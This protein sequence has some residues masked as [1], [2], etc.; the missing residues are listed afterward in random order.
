MLVCGLVY[1]LL[2]L[3]RLRRGKWKCLKKF[4]EKEQKKFV[5]ILLAC[6]TLAMLL[7]AMD[8][9]GGTE[10]TE[11]LRGSYGE[12]SYTT[13]YEVS[14]E[15]ELEKE[16]FS[17]KVEEREYTE[18][19][20]QEIF[21]EMMDKL[22]V[23]VLGENQSFDRVEEDLCLVDQIE[24]YPVEIRWELSNYKVLDAEGRIL[25]ENT[26]KEGSLVELRARLLYGEWESVYVTNVMVYPKQK[27][28]KEKWL[29]LLKKRVSDREEESRQELA[30]SLPKDLEGKKV[31]WE[32]KADRRGYL[33][34]LFGVVGCALLYWNT[35]QEQKEALQKRQEQ[36]QRDYP[37]LLS[38]LSLLLGTG[39]TVR[40]AWVRVVESYEELKM[41]GGERAVYEEMRVACN[42][43]QGGISEAEC[44]ERFGR[45][46]GIAVYFKFGALLSQ[47]LRKGSRGLT[48]LLRVETIQAFENRKSIARRKGEEAGTKL[49]VPMMGMLLVV[50]ILVIVPAFLSMDL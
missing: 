41:Q 30:F 1:I 22:D 43:M 5:W 6:N 27:T 24:D 33:L 40:Q 28:G 32:K 9:A 37:D 11:V 44:Y 25:T 20:V 12:G 4:T 7:F 17:L 29:E 10:V 38:K 35:R 21:R 42:E 26:T 3:W 15:G 49:L 31:L 47:N 2:L 39:M 50:M 8:V 48:D 19:E 46:C 13:E 45:R 36:L 14:V 23:L 18:E 16:P 34:L